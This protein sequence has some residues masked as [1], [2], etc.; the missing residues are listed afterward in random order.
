M[1]EPDEEFFEV[2]G[3]PAYR[4]E[5]GCYTRPIFQVLPSVDEWDDSDRATWPEPMPHH[6][7]AR[8]T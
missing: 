4:W 6:D 5:P 8:M 2:D 7:L 3:V 1:S